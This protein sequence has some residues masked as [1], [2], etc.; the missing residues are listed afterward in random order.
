[1]WDFPSLVP[2][3]TVVGS[4]GGFAI[5]LSTQLNKIKDLIFIHID[6]VNTKVEAIEK[7]LIEKIEY[8][9]RHDDKRFGDIRDSLWE[10]RLRNA[11]AEGMM[12]YSRR[13]APKSKEEKNTK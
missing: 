10:M 13:P 7:S 3:I 12:Q 1:M 11:A 6:R 9:E 8:H 4:I 5:W 2:V